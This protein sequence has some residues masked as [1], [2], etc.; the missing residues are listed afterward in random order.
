MCWTFTLHYMLCDCDR[1]G[2]K[3]CDKA[4]AAADRAAANPALPPSPPCRIEY[5]E[6]FDQTIMSY[7]PDHNQQVP[8]PPAS[9]D[10]QADDLELV[11]EE[12]QDEEDDDDDE[13]EEEEG[14]TKDQREARVPLTPPTL[15][16]AP[17]K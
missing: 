13:E 16:A 17:R 4:S 5:E 12:D 14:D 3:E 1:S 2:F 10:W 15:A 9:Y 6:E 8:T 11:E 7:C